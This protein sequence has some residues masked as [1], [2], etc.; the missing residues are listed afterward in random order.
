LEIFLGTG[1]D[2]LEGVTVLMQTGDDP[3]A[4]TLADFDTDGDLDIATANKG[5]K[6]ATILLNNGAGNFSIGKVFSAGNF[7]RFITSGDINGDGV[8]DIVV[9]NNQTGDLT[10]IR[11][12]P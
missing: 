6:S 1:D 9:A 2:F 10:I 7:P 8:A 11:S 4:L 3:K 12:Q 5:S